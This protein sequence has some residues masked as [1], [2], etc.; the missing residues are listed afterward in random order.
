MK[1]AREP[2]S[3]RPKPCAS[4]P[5]KSPRI[6]PVR[7][8]LLALVGRRQTVIRDQLSPQ[9][10]PCSRLLF[11]R[12]TGVHHSPSSSTIKLSSSLVE[13]GAYPPPNWSSEETRTWELWSLGL[14]GY[15]T[16]SSANHTATVYPRGDHFPQ[17]ICITRR[18][19]LKDITVVPKQPVVAQ[20][21]GNTNVD[22]K[23]GENSKVKDKTKFQRTKDMSTL[24]SK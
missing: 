16:P 5:E 9:K 2:A 12:S 13:F 14:P 11:S 15:R 19:E 18:G 23:V 6:L 24:M 20:S 22:Q 17:T 8:S 7:R 4:I 1:P 21:V 10:P 3:S